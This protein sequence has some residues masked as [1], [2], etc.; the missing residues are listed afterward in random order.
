[1]KL[2]GLGPD[3]NV[4]VTYPLREL[5]ETVPIGGA[6]DVT[7]PEYTLTWSGDTV[8]EIS[9]EGTVCPLYQREYFRQEEA[10]MKMTTFYYPEEE[11]S[12]P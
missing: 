10:P 6:V 12:F 1:M 7:P 3:E 2:T 4:T 5:V 9:P 11:L 8:V